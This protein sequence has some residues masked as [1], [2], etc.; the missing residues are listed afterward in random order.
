MLYGNNQII[1]YDDVMKTKLVAVWSLA[2]SIQRLPIARRQHRY[3]LMTTSI[4]NLGLCRKMKNFQQ[5]WG[6]D[7]FSQKFWTDARNWHAYVD[8]RTRDPYMM[9]CFT[10]LILFIDIN[11]HFRFYRLITMTY[12]YFE[13][14]TNWSNGLSGTDNKHT[15]MTNIGDNLSISIVPLNCCDYVLSQVPSTSFG[16]PSVFTFNPMLN[17]NNENGVGSL[18]F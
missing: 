9:R 4:I 17:R 11:F 6:D 2:T 14:H 10:T 8:L 7:K 18:I 3:R 13:L 15:L 1:Q 16:T 5:C 12:C